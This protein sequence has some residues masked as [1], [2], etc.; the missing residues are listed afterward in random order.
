MSNLNSRANPKKKRK[1][2]SVLTKKGSAQEKKLH[3]IMR[4]QSADKHVALDAL[5]FRAIH[6]TEE[7][8]KELANMFDPNDDEQGIEE[9]KVVQ[10]P[11]VT[12]MPID[13]NNDTP[14]CAVC[15]G[16][17][18]AAAST[19]SVSTAEAVMKPI[20]TKIPSYP[21][22]LYG[23]DVV[24]L[25]SLIFQ[26]S[27]ALNGYKV[28]VLTS[29]V[30]DTPCLPHGTNV[31]E[32]IAQEFKPENTDMEFINV[33]VFDCRGSAYPWSIAGGIRNI[34]EY[35]K[36]PGKDRPLTVNFSGG[37][38]NDSIMNKYFTQL[39]KNGI[40]VVVAAGNE[41][42]DCINKSPA[43]ASITTAI[44][45]IGATEGQ[46][47]ANYSNFSTNQRCVDL[48]LPGCLPMTNPITGAKVKG[49]GTSFS[50]PLQTGRVLVYKAT[51]KNAKPFAIKTA[52]R[53]NTISI[54]DPQGYV[55]P[56]ITEDMAFQW[57]AQK[58]NTATAKSAAKKA[59]PKK[60]SIRS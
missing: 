4:L 33:A 34:L 36:G 11:P 25:D 16:T 21:K 29:Y 8:A 28:K 14:E 47:K 19:A 37:T 56:T 60:A 18:T 6:L 42:Q 30:G 53:K 17:L 12:Y 59:G 24:I 41:S 46:A 27:A 7:E 39:V 57:S 1:Q 45:S 20:L 3:E 23:Q 32:V 2:Y 51:H 31:A 50:A 49:C 22:K 54:T 13:A 43:N 48:Y 5:D 58:Q 40:D 10:L 26:N 15:P 38:Q 52:M 55:L 9:S 35:K 44:Q